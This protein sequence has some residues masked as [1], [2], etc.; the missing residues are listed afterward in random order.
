M[1]QAL[2]TW[3][4]FIVFVMLFVALALYI[5]KALYDFRKKIKED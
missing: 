3:L 1:I 4:F 5:G 2:A